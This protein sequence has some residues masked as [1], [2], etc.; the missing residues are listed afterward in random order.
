MVSYLLLP[1]LCILNQIALRASSGRGFARLVQ[2]GEGFEE[3]SDARAAGRR[4][5]AGI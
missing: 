1:G 5:L 4:K 3:F 2:D